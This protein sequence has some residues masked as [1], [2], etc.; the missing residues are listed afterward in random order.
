MRMLI[1]LNQF[2]YRATVPW[3]GLVDQQIDWEQGVSQIESWLVYNVGHR[4]TTWA[5]DD[6]YDNYLLGV[7]FLL[8]P[9]QTLFLLRWSS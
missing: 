8:K 7:S 4:M 2:P 3:P 1:D 5:W 9:H 6:S